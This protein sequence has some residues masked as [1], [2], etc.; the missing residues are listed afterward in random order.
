MSLVVL[1]VNHRTTPLSLLERMTISPALVPK[2]LGDL[3]G[4]TYVSE[5]VLLSTCNRTEVYVHAEKFHGAY[6]DVRDF[7]AQFCQVAPEDFADHLYTYHDR[8]AV[9]H[10]FAVASGLDSAVLGEHE[11]QGQVKKAWSVA[12]EEG[13]AGPTLNDVFRAALEVGKRARTETGIGRHVASVSHAAVVLAEKR[14]GTLEGKRVFVLGAGDMGNGMTAAA[15]DA[16]G[17]FDSLVVASRT[18]QRASD[19]AE[20]FGGRAVH[21]DEVD[22]ELIQ[23]DVVFTSTSA[24]SYMIEFGQMLRVAEQRSGRPMLLVDIAM[25]R[26]VDPKVSEIP[27][28]TVLDMAAVQ[29]Y[30]EEQMGHRRAEVD[31][32]R[33]IIE[34]GLLRYEQQTSVREVA[35]MIAAFRGR[36]EDIRQA[37]MERFAGRLSELEPGEREAV[38]SLVR[39][40]VG[41]LLYAPTERLKESAD[42]PRGERLAMSLRELFDL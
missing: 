8:E 3:A 19:L 33:E 2:A 36:A 34:L 27:G 25:P 16:V 7:V 6:Q 23:A 1:G 26:D 20:H 11:I 41:K 15:A 5:A 18:W 24:T 39:G 30:T 32:V 42:S 9:D 13:T 40:V 21:L 12:Q 28:V 14:L 35:P 17:D 38:E 29:A 22:Q 4:R 10:L 31:R 37:E